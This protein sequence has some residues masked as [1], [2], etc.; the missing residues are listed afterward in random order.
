MYVR[1]IRINLTVYR[2]FVN[3]NTW[4]WRT[5]WKPLSKTTPAF[6]EMT[7]NSIGTWTLYSYPLKLVKIHHHHQQLSY[8][9]K[10]SLK[11][12]INQE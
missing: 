8:P 6:P 4:P 7:I 12:V 3:I 11:T 9:I 2:K 1:Y 5:F 10:T